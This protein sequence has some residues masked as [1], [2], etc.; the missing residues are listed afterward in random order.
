MSRCMCEFV[1]GGKLT[2][3]CGY[4]LGQRLTA[5]RALTA[6]DEREAAL[7]EEIATAMTVLKP[8][9]PESG[10]VDACKQVKQVA[11]SEADN[12]EKFEAALAEAQ[13]ENTEQR[14]ALEELG[15][16]LGREQAALISQ[17]QKVAAFREWLRSQP[18]HIVHDDVDLIE[19]L[20]SLGLVGV[21][22]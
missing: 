19:K 6:A 10:L 14:A 1:V 21:E 13:R 9:M 7:R 12:S 18:S 11:I 5:E 16:A 8:N 4:H 20:D 22:P 2:E 15:G 17:R 3:E